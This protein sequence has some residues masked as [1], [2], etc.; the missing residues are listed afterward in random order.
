MINDTDPSN[1]IQQP[2]TQLVDK[3]KSML[4]LK[5]YNYLTKRKHEISDFYM[6]PKLHKSKRINEIVQKQQCEYINIEENIIVK[7]HP[8]VADTVYHTSSISE[9]LHIIME[10]SLAM[11][12][13]IAK[14]SLDFKNRLDKYCLTGITLSTCDIKSLYTNIRHDLFHTAVEYWT[15][16]LQDV[17]PLLQRFNKQFILENLSIILEFNY[18]YINGIYIHQIKG[19]AMGAKF[20]VVGSNLVVTNEE[21]KMLPLV[22]QLYPQDFVDFVIRNYFRFLDQVF[23][24]WLDNFDIEPFYSMINNLDT[25]L[26]FIFENPSKSLN[27]LDI[28]IRIVENNLV[29][30]IHYKRTNSFNYLTYTSCHS[31]HTNNNISLS[32]A[33]RI[34]NI[35]TNNGE[36]R[37]K[38]L[39]EH[40]LDRI[41]P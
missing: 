39:K 38:E 9:I 31:P 29:F 24:K 11:I 17:L 4:T 25:N 10:P 30:D 36:N 20:A 7:A 19:T 13:H 23:H 6:L 21:V 34:V 22:P 41:H 1:I 33:K 8:I 26:K 16:K 15:E 28:N 27:F 40:L 35:V 3:Y 14:D 18:F 12:S 2:V 32:L 37:L 5:E